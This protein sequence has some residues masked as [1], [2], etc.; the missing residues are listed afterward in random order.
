MQQLLLCYNNVPLPPHPSSYNPKLWLLLLLAPYCMENQS[1]SNQSPHP[2]DPEAS[3]ETITIQVAD[4]DGM[5]NP[6]PLQT[7][8]IRLNQIEFST[9]NVAM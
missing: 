9:D 3:D 6:V 8:S 2:K 7:T 4:L 5:S 1:F